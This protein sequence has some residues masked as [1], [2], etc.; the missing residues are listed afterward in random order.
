MCIKGMLGIVMT[1]FKLVTD[2]QLRDLNAVANYDTAYLVRSTS[3]KFF[4]LQAVVDEIHKA[5][6]A[7][8][9]RNLASTQLANERGKTNTY[10]MCVVTA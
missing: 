3:P 6:T 9:K 4:E 1:C 8:L 10:S 7:R 5:A 2:Q